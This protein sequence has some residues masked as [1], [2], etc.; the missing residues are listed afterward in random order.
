MRVIH[1]CLLRGTLPRRCTP[2]SPQYRQAARPCH[3]HLL[4]LRDC[5]DGRASAL[6]MHRWMS[7]DGAEVS[8]A[9]PCSCQRSLGR[10]AF[11]G[12]LLP[13]LSVR[14]GIE[15]MH[16]GFVDPDIVHADNSPV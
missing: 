8:D 1:L 9:S 6:R 2:T 16:V 4:P 13:W 5:C 15:T 12:R 11:R 14:A 3:A 10:L 7:N